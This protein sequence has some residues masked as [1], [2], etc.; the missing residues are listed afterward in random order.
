MLVDTSGSIQVRIIDRRLFSSTGSLDEIEASD[1]MARALE[2]GDGGVVDVDWIDP[3]SLSEPSLRG[4]DAIILSRPDLIGDRG[5]DSIKVFVDSGGLVLATPPSE[6]DSHVWL[7]RMAEALGISWQVGVEAI[8]ADDPIGLGGEQPGGSILS[9][10][11]NEL[12][13]LAEPIEVF[14]RLDVDVS[15]GDGRVLLRCADESP[16]LICWDPEGDRSGTIVLLSSSPHLDWTNLPIKPLMVPLMQELVR[17]GVST[18]RNSSQLLAG[19]V[20]GGSFTGVR[21]IT[22]PGGSSVSI[23]STR[24]FTT[25]LIRTGHWVARDAKGSALTTI[26]VN[27]DVDAADPEV[28]DVKEVV[29]RFGVESGLEIIP[30]DQLAGRFT[31]QESNP[32]W[33]L[34]LLV[35]ALLLLITETILNR[36]FSRSVSRESRFVDSMEAVS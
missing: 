8:T 36:F 27:P 11:D 19:D 25:P 12:D 2:P 10:L 34:L 21:E 9:R 26:V 35:A 29:E 31:S 32:V 23:D 4:V 13:Q 17:E 7:D 33:S 1:W 5:W 30:D 14:K 16:L 24:S 3:S 6:L 20:P 15:D 28:T 18:S 22:G